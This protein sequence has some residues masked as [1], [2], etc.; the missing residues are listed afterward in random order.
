MDLELTGRTALITGGSQ[1]IGLATAIALAREGANVAILA[2]NPDELKK[3]LNVIRPNASAGLLSIEG[4]VSDQKSLS[5]AVSEVESKFG[6]VDILVNNAGGTANFGTFDELEDKDWEETFNLNLFSVV[7]AVRA[8]LPGMRSRDW[9]RIIN[10]ASESAL[11]PDAF[12]PHYA[13]SKAA[14]LNVTKSL[15]KLTAGSGIRVNAVSPAFVKTPILERMLADF[16]KGRGVT[17]EEG[18]RLFLKEERPNITAGRAGRPEEVAAIIA[19]MCSPVS[20]FINGA[21]IR[22]DSGSVSTIA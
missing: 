5:R 8:V 3:A 16:A 22:V 21:N 2:R 15:S 18:E 4:D 13:A 14:L 11:Q 12:F 1:G 6:A 9:G 17:T 7:R 20:D 10:I 19:V